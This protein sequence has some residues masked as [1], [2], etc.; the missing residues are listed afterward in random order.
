V[1]SAKVTTPRAKIN[2]LMLA[3]IAFVMLGLPVGL[4]G[5]AWPTLRADFNLPLDALGLLLIASTIGYTLASFFIARLINSFGIGALLVFSSL[6]LAVAAFGYPLAPNWNMIVG[7]GA[8]AG[9]GGGLMDAG[10]NTYL[11]AEYQESEMQWLHASFGIGATLS[12]IIMTVSLSEFASWRPGYIFVGVLMA[13]MTVAFWLTYSAWKVPQKAFE[14]AAEQPGLMDY[15]TSVWASLLR[16]QTV[17][18][19]LL[20]LLY[21]GAELILGNWT[22]TLFTEGRGI[23]PQIAGIWAGGFW[24]IFTIGRALG[25]LYAHRVRLNTLLLGAMALALAGS[26]LFWWNPLPLVGVAGVFVAGF[27]MAPIFAGLISSTRQRVGERHAANTVGIQI[28]AANVGGTLLPALAGFLAQRYSLEA[29]PVMLAASLLGL[30]AL[31]GLSMRM[32]API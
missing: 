18:G 1:Q 28:S 14:T 31:Y 6:T 20:F 11:A 26:I 22:Y 27:G 10:L 16:S 25:G 5:V 32:K 12:P 8:L 4:L 19:M 30:L 23:S 24:G 15:Q 3:Y 2:A 29:V 17:I 13:I 9:F 21:T 7:I